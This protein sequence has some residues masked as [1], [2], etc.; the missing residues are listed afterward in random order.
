MY[1]SCVVSKVNK[2]RNL[3]AIWEETG[4]LDLD[5]AI[6]VH[7]REIFPLSKIFKNDMK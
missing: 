1:K 4:F 5:K 3:I 6:F 2:R 7:V